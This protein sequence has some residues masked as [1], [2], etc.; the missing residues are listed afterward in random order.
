MNETQALQ[1]RIENGGFGTPGGYYLPPQAQHEPS[2]KCCGEPYIKT[3]ADGFRCLGCSHSY[4]GWALR[5]AGIDTRLI[6]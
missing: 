6:G 3:D 5:N 4:S 1:D 2:S